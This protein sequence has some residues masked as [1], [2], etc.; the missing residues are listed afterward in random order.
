LGSRTPEADRAIRNAQ[1]VIG[2]GPYVEQCRQLLGTS[3]EIVRSPIG[4][5]VE[6]ARQAVDQAI[7]GAQVAVVCSGDPGIY[8]MASLVLEEAAEARIDVTIVPGVTAALAAA[9]QLGAPL[10]HDHVMISL[11]DLLTP[12]DLIVRRVMAARDAD[13]VIA[14]YN[15]RSKAR[16][17]QLAAVRDLLLDGRSA[18]T[19]VGIATDVGRPEAVTSITTLAGIDPDLVGMTTCVIIGSSTT[20]V[21]AGRMVTPRG[22]R[23]E[24]QREPGS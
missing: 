7:A 21:I 18:D 23:R 3:Q 24:P 8:A 4:A 6:R 12:W 14:L 22:Y 20:R 17:W 10:G 2:Y 19:P 5:E 9:A 15:P 16:D 1:V 13:L 11:S